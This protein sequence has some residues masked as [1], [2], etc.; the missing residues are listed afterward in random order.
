[1]NDISVVLT[2]LLSLV[3]ILTIATNIVVQVIKGLV[4]KSFPT[5]L[6]CTLV[7][8]LVTF[9]AA[10][11]YSN[12]EGITFEPWQWVG[13]I[14]LAF[15]VSFAA[16]YGFD[17]LKEMCEQWKEG[18]RLTEEDLVQ[19]IEQFAADRKLSVEEVL[20]AALQSLEEDKK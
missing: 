18:H 14:G 1:M 10:F 8:F 12:H 7:A 15:A 6:L 13:C 11:V 17:K 9:A 4:P 5:N 19:N 16:M 3:L 20:T 2:Q